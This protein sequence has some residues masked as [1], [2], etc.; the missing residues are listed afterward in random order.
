MKRRGLKKKLNSMLKE[1]VIV[2]NDHEKKIE[3]KF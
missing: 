3:V 2:S 1:V